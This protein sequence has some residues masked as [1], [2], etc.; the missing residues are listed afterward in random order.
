MGKTTHILP[1]LSLALLTAPFVRFAR[2]NPPADTVVPAAPGVLWRDPGDLKSRDVLNGPGGQEDAPKGPFVFDKEDLNGTNPKFVVRAADGTKWKVKLGEEA[3]PETSA[4]RLVW[5]VGYFADEDYF[6]PNIKIDNMPATLHRGASK[7]EPD[8]MMHDVRLKRYLDDEKKAGE[9]SWQKNP[10][11]GT[12]ELNGLRVM[13]ALINNWDLKNENN[14]IYKAKAEGAKAEAAGGPERIYLVSD[15]GASFGTPGRSVTRAE[16]KGNLKAYSHSEFI[17]RK[18]DGVV[19]FNVPNRPAMIHVFE[20]P[21]YVK[22]MELRSIGENIPIE[23]CRWIGHILAG[24]SHEQ[25]ASA[26]I[27]AGYSRDEALGFSAEVE[28]RIAQLNQL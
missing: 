19:D 18:H 8:G 2:A 13:M 10:F 11:T 7:V 9:W 15:L 21:E 17:R 14:A 16:S 22:R 6:M 23:D 28:S 5:A 25:I 24:L 3:R 20:L 4:S 12:R 26:F 27:A 1:L